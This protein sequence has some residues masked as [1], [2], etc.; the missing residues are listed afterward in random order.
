MIDVSK[1]IFSTIKKVIKYIRFL[2]HN[3]PKIFKKI[4]N[5]I[6]IDDILKESEYRDMPQGVLKKLIDLRVNCI[7]NNPEFVIE[8]I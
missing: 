1:T 8:Y 2:G 7:L 3:D 5:L 6:I 4:L